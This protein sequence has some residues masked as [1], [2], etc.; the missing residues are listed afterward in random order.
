MGTYVKA[1]ALQ[2]AGQELQQITALE[3]GR[4]D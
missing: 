3:A 4:G 1:E 2:I